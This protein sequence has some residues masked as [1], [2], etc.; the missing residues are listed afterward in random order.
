MGRESAQCAREV[1]HPE[2]GGI[3]T[4]PS[5]AGLSASAA[6]RTAAAGPT[7]ASLF[8]DCARA[9]ANAPAVIQAGSAISYKELNGRVNRLVSALKARGVSR[10]DRLAI[11]SE[12]RPEYIELILACAKIGALAACQNWRQAAPELSHCLKLVEPKLIFASSRF[13][14]TAENLG[15]AVPL[16]VFGN[17]YES[18]VEAGSPEEPLLAADAEDGLLILYTSGTTGLPKG[19]VISHRAIIARAL[20]MM[21]DWSIR[22][23][24]GSIAWSPLFHMAAADPALAAL[25]HGAPV[26]VVDGFN[27]EMISNALSEIDVGWFVLMPGMIERMIE[28]RRR[29]PN[30]PRRVAVVGCMANLVP[31]AQ[32][33]EISGLL[34]APFL[35]S[36][37]ST[38]TGIAPASGDKIPPGVQPVS[39]A[40]KQTSSCEIRLVDHGDREVAPGEVGEMTLR[41]TTL[42]SGYWNAPEASERDFRGGWFHMGDDF[43]RSADGTLQFIDRRKYLIKSGG[44]NIY[45]AELECVLRESIRIREAVVVRQPDDRWG[46]VPVA[47][48]VPQDER[49]TADEVL[50]LLEGKIARYKLPKRVVFLRDEDLERNATGK[51]QRQPLEHRLVA[52][53]K[54]E[55]GK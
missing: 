45:P 54:G 8:R 31:P 42:F 46:E 7:V 52:E 23:T 47:F 38:E 36:F 51:I 32:I 41:S 37:G 4:G 29:A 43:I 34:A 18:I 10:G 21:A 39:F 2:S 35:N 17:S 20:V 40:K 30:A 15:L 5:F 3:V 9:N 44:E 25:C 12:N 1:L 28:V 14:P 53:M 16:V 19:A 50:A 11:V 33:A 6:I 13:A 26:Y 27:A 55:A 24:D 49:L 22:R 48:I